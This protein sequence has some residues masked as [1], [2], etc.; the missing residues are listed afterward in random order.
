[1]WLQA[2]LFVEA[3]VTKIRLTGGEPSL[4]G[5]I[6]SLTESLQAL[7]GLQAIGIT[8]N[9]IALRRKLPALKAVGAL[10]YH[11][12]SSRHSSKASCIEA[13]QDEAVAW[14]SA[15]WYRTRQLERFG[16]T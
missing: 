12:S 14:V 6:V 11:T 7:P 5:D 16:P 2:R 13:Q 3:G 8:S 4:R 10:S 1:M 15:S 9:G